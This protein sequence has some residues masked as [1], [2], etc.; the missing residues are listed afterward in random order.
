M[1]S[2]LI[3]SICI[4][5]LLMFIF[6]CT[7]YSD[8]PFELSNG[9]VKN[10]EEDNL[11]SSIV[12]QVTD[13]STD[14]PIVGA[15]VTAESGGE[16]RTDTTD[17]NGNYEIKV[18]G[19]GYYTVK[20]SADGYIETYYNNGNEFYVE[21]GEKVENILV[22]LM[23]SANL[24]IVATY[25]SPNSWPYD[26]TFDGTNIWLVGREGDILYK[27][28]PSTGNTKNSF[29]L[30]KRVWSSGGGLT[31]KDGYL[32]YTSGDDTT[33]I[34]QLS[35]LDGS[36]VSSIS[37]DNFDCCGMAYDGTYFWL[38][39]SSNNFLKKINNSGNTILSFS[40]YEY[41][42][43]GGCT[44]ANG[45]LWRINDY[46]ERIEKIDPENGRVLLFV[47]TP[48]SNPA[49]ITFDGTNFW[50]SDDALDKIFKVKIIE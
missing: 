24:Q 1:K 50:I 40:I 27:I 26:M 19:S 31:Y 18:M 48:G 33:K 4:M 30:S 44:F 37:R 9:K 28:D 35:K 12:G 22:Y 5:L 8:N 29:S 14:N 2:I 17:E 6:Q 15:L 45:Y 36:V 25:N 23:K 13:A 16:S 41:G 11:T 34:F 38:V 43:R 49:G 46:N 47:S 21:E 20:A 42:T 7:N 39:D 3:F 32:W 10:P